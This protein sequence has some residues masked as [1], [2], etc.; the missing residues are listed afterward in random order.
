MDHKRHKAVIILLAVLIS[1]LAGCGFNANSE[2]PGEPDDGQFAA[3]RSTMVAL[4]DQI[5]ANAEKAGEVLD[6]YA[7]AWDNPVAR[8]QDFTAALTGVRLTLDGPVNAVVNGRAAVASS[9]A[10]LGEPPRSL[11]DAHAVLQDMFAD[12]SALVQLCEQPS[13]TL[14]AFKARVDEL[15]K[16][17]RDGHAQMQTSLKKRQRPMNEPE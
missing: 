11:T 4:A 17:I 3:Y 6:A 13:G 1:L 12:Y 8:N 9:L 15:H 7:E 2:N 16:R 14:E 10:D 5:A